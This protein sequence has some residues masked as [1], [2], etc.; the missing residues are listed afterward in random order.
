MHPELATP[1]T[2]VV[3]QFLLGRAL[4][5]ELGLADLRNP[6]VPPPEPTA[7]TRSPD[8]SYARELAVALAT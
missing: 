1:G 8:L 5:G 4:T 6:L 7:Q 2:R 3:N